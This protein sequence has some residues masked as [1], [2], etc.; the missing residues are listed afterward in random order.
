MTGAVRALFA[1]ICAFKRELTTNCWNDIST[2]VS[3]KER[4]SRDQ[5]CRLGDAI[6]NA[7]DILKQMRET[8]AALKELEPDNR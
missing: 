4:P 3:T 7:E 1:R 6:N 2:N 8:L 5:F